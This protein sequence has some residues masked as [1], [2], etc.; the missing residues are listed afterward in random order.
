MHQKAR[1]AGL[2]RLVSLLFL[3]L[4]PT[5]GSAQKEAGNVGIDVSHTSA[6]ISR[7]IYGQ[8]L[9]HIGGLVNKGIWAEMLDDGKFY[10]PITSHPPSGQ[11]RLWRMA[12]ETVDATITIG[13]KPGVEVQEQALEFVPYVATVPPFSVSICSF[14]VQ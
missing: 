3:L 13:Q 12:P 11:G 5:F 9:E 14:A 7:C 4:V 8:F 1:I 10:F 6:P 2:T